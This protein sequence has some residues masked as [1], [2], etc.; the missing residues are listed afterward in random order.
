MNVYITMNHK[1]VGGIIAFII[2]VVC[3]VVVATGEGYGA[4]VALADKPMLSGYQMSHDYQIQHPR[5]VCPRHPRVCNCGSFERD[6]PV[7]GRVHGDARMRVGGGLSGDRWDPQHLNPKKV[8]G[9]LNPDEYKLYG[10]RH[11]QYT[12]DPFKAH[13]WYNNPDTMQGVWP[14]SSIFNSNEDCLFADTSL[15]T[16]V[17]AA[18]GYN[19]YI[20][21]EGADG[22]FQYPDSVG[23]QTPNYYQLYDELA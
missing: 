13:R 8:E 6:Y 21:N 5:M 3:L 12:G 22:N 1:V 20:D 11:H 18:G 19:D 9:N 7:W 2:V 15:P 23:S 14:A 17:A 4:P 10:W 16:A